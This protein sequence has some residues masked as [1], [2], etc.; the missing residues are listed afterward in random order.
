MGLEPYRFSTQ[1]D[2]LLRFTHKVSQ[3]GFEST[4]RFLKKKLRHLRHSYRFAQSVLEMGLE[5]ISLAA[6]DFESFVYTIPP[7]QQVILTILA[8]GKSLPEKRKVI[9]RV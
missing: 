7:L 2:T 6:N 1:L 9:N 5:P 3:S 4:Q 8:S